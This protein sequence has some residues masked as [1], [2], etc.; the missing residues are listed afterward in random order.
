MPKAIYR[1]GMLGIALLLGAC[2]SAAPQPLKQLAKT[3]IDGVIDAFIRQEQV[4]LEALLIKFYHRNPRELAKQPGA[5]IDSRRRQL[6][7]QSGRLR[8]AELGGREDIAALELVFDPAFEGDRVF[9][10]MAGLTGMLRKS[11]DYQH[12]MFFFDRL[13]PL[14]LSRSARNIEV[15]MWKLRS[16]RDSSGQLFLLG[17]HSPD[18]LD[19]ASFTR[20]W[21]KLIAL[22]D[23]LATI[24][25]GSEERTLRALVH[26]TVSTVFMPI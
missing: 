5:T 15:L 1:W 16:R 7:G 9:A 12:E 13:D 17:S 19:N 11:Y 14:K 18:G 23:M 21:G 24:V 20:L 2:S 22:Q 8:F 10:L 26:G 3:D 4:Y 25:D 6:F